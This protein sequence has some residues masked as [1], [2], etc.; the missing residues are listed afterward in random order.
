MPWS[1]SVTWPPTGGA[2]VVPVRIDPL[3]GD[4]RAAAAVTHPN[5][6]ASK[7]RQANATAAARSATMV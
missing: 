7:C 3:P 1:G 5:A 2:M 4:A 6:S